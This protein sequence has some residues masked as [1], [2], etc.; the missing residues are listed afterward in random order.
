ML[1]YQRVI[2]IGYRKKI[3]GI[4]AKYPTSYQIQLDSQKKY[5]HFLKKTSL[6]ILIVIKV[7]LICMYNH[8][9]PH[10]MSPHIGFYDHTCH[11]PHIVP[12]KSQL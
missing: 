8:L 2:V 6:H 1:V 11:M 5:P 7:H 9:Y 10:D 3:L 12:L 4:K